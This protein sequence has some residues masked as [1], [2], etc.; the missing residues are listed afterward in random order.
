MGGDVA[1]MDQDGYVTHHGRANDIMKALGYRVSPLEVE[2]VLL[3]HPAVAEV[4]CAE[5]RV[6]A[7][8]N[9]IGAFIVPRPG[10]T[11]EEAELERFAAERLAAYKRPR[12]FTFL[13]AL[14]RT[15]NGKIVRAKLKL[16]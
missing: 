1:G 7:D 5:V 8:V 14:P 11:L 9:V 6:R 2:T 12:V 16:P 10:A 13:D 15:A 4:A 3:Q